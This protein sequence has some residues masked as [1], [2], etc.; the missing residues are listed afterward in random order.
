[1]NAVIFSIILRNPRV[2]VLKLWGRNKTNLGP[3][4]NNTDKRYVY[5]VEITKFLISRQEM[6]F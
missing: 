5:N 4:I 1:M 2:Y 6:I 3:N